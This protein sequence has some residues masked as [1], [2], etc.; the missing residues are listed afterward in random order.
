MPP[1]ESMNMELAKLRKTLLLA[2]SL[3]VASMAAYY[4]QA[5]VASFA[6]PPPPQKL[7]LAV[8]T[9]PG[10]GLPYLAA[11]MGYFSQ[12]G[13]EVTLQPHTSGRDA[14]EATL[15]KHADLGTVAAIPVMFATMNG[16]QVSIVAT[17]FTAAR[18]HGIVARRD[19][20]ILSL[21]DLKGKTIGV[22]FRTDAH[23][24]L[25]SLLARHRLSLDQAHIENIAP[26]KMQ[27]ALKSGEVDAVST[28]EPW[29]SDVNQ[30]TGANG[31]EFR[32]ATDVVLDY[33]LAG[34][35]DWIAANGD[36]VQRMLRALLRAKKFAEE[37]PQQAHAM[38]IALMKIDP[39]TFSTVGPN[40]RFVVKLD[41]NLVVTLEDQARWA[42]ENKFSEQTRIPNFLNVIDSTALQAIQADAVSIVR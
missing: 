5:I 16:Q 8:T 17:I 29:L 7:T 27:A 2:T 4:W 37:K 3:I 25:S 30:A 23:Y 9:Y 1:L 39:G 12:E 34:R 13:L 41:Q 28:W 42:I 6:P 40:Y 18:A 35:K 31:I 38:I 14:L 15:E 26:E 11:G 36:K 32:T 33:N 22:T 19:R 24:I 20:G 21:A 10:S